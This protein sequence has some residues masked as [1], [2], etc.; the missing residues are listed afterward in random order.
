MKEIRLSGGDAERP[1]ASEMAL[2]LSRHRANLRTSM[3]CIPALS[4]I[5]ALGLTACD[6]MN[7]PISSGN[8]DP[9]AT[10]GGQVGAIAPQASPFK[11]GQF[12]RAAMDNTAFYRVRP[13][14]EASADKLLVR[15][16]SMKV[17]AT[18]GS[19]VKVEL[20]SGDIGFVPAVMLEDPNSAPPVPTTSTSE[21]QVYPPVPGTGLGEPLPGF[22]PAGQP[23]IGSIPTVIDPE[24][25][26][27]APVTE[28]IPTPP[29]EPEK[30]PL[31]PPA[32]E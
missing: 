2:T 8:F 1:L 27:V 17:I 11:A 6:T 22:D 13:K 32:G 14:G 28:T 23:P 16:T 18:A 10:P 9:L 12:A 19:Y 4:A 26:P 29:V 5:A 24:A 15:G 3:K 20:D 31:P 7:T 21:V 25:P 30:I